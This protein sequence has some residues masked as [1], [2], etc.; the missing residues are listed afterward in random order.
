MVR[1]LQL[2]D[3]HLLAEAFALYRG[4]NPLRGLRHG[5]KQALGSLKHRPDLLLISGDLCQDES[6]AGYR[7]LR[8]LAGPFGI[9]LA[10]LPGN[11]DDP[12]LLRQVFSQEA[13]LVPTVLAPAVLPL[14]RWRLI[15]LSSHQRG[16][17]AGAID[18]AQLDWLGCQLAGDDAPTWVA[19][20]HP[21]VPIGSPGLDAVALQQPE[22]LL[23][24]LTASPAVKGVVF[25]HVHQHWQ[26][27]LPGRPEVPL[28]ACPSTLCA[29]EAVQPCPLGRPV[30]PGGRWL[31]LG[32][33]GCWRQELL[34]WSAPP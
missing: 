4:V 2:S 13:S 9:P 12:A 32:P 26:G 18:G 19:I 16:S 33:D 14:G 17:T 23:T 10:L 34:R 28:L 7:Q 24:L 15:L 31:E 8:E 27:A 6:L 1:V 11:H 29:F 25:G 20:H 3:P 22:R 21:P 5:L 30:D